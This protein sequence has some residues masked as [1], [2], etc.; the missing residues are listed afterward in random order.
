M[1]LS[2]LV[3]FSIVILLLSFNSIHLYAQNDSKDFGYQPEIGQ[4]GKDVIWVPTSDELV[5][6]MLE[7]AQVTP[8]DFVIDLGSGDGRTVIAAAKRGA[9]A[10]GIE[11][12]PDMIELSVK[13]AKEAGVTSKTKF[14][15]A[16]LFEFDFSEA[17]V[18]TM[19]LLPEINL[20]LRPQLLEL[21]PGTRIVS[22]TF[23][24]GEWKP[25]KKITIDGYEGNDYEEM[26]EENWNNWTTAL[27][28]IVPAKV[29]GKWKFGKGEISIRQEFQ[30]INGKYKSGNK[31]VE[32]KDGK[33][34]GNEITFGLDGKI[35]TGHV[36]GD[37][38]MEGTSTS[39]TTKKEW[40]ATYSGI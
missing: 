17:S 34:N 21:K 26:Y 8:G 7:M 20:K 37:K 31:T 16:D 36:N 22:N 11:Y 2:G 15:K 24:M 1:K 19:F 30:M 13:N 39:G 14:I 12:N 32:I 5:D 18:I 40:V 10:L 6:K 23:T 25:D 27:M 35:Y 38:T 33:L 29:E 3:I 28:W 4:V 9:Q